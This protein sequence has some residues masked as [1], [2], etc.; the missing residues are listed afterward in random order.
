MLW[1]YTNTKAM[2]D[3]AGINE[4]ELPSQREK[5]SGVN[6]FSVGDSKS[7]LAP[8]LA[9]KR[10]PDRYGSQSALGVPSS[11]PGGRGKASH[12]PRLL[13][14]RFI[15]GETLTQNVFGD[16]SVKPSVLIG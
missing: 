9:S 10:V 2:V 14:D 6:D 4:A 12:D 11:L 16:Q 13:S 1:M 15:N 3:V 8:G 5:L 7:D